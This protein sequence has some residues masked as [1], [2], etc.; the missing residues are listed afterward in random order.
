MIVFKLLRVHYRPEGG[1]LRMYP[2]D[3]IAAT[4]ATLPNLQCNIEYIVWVHA[5]GV[6]YN[7]SSLPRMVN[8]PGRGMFMLYN[9]SYS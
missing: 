6:L 8:L 4:S 7:S 9:L 1:S 2:V 3:N 5:S